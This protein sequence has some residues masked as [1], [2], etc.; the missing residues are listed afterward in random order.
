ME[1]LILILVAIVIVG[2]ITKVINNKQSKSES[3]PG[4]EYQYGRKEALMT[5][6][7]AAF[8]HRLNAVAGDRYFIFPQIH[9]SAL[10]I[11][12]TKGRYWKAAFQRINRSSVDYV[13]CNKQTLKV[14]YA[15]ELD[16][17]THDTAKRKDRDVG[18]EAMFLSIGLPLVRFRDVETLTDEQIANQFEIAAQKDT[19]QAST[20]DVTSV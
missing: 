20:I 15:V 10:L 16:D 12:K 19:V 6:R 13:L 8:Y 11:N 14:A 18:V 1:Y 7:E 4:S 9:L 17:A 3:V 5:E 2:V